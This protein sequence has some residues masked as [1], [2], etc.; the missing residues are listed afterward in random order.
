[1]SRVLIS[2]RQHVCPHTMGAQRGGSLFVQWK[3]IFFF[4]LVGPELVSSA[5]VIYSTCPIP[6]RFLCPRTRISPAS[7]STT[8][9]P[10]FWQLLSSLSDA[11]VSFGYLRRVDVLSPFHTSTL[12]WIMMGPLCPTE[13]GCFW[14]VIFSTENR[15]ST[16]TSYF[17]EKQV[18]VFGEYF[19]TFFS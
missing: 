16:K 4:L 18:G 1:M 14:W 10:L 9:V 19:V 5:P 8:L 12:F 2:L 7:Y 13:C 17:T 3:N 6:I 15:L 11:A